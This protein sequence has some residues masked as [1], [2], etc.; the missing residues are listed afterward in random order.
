MVILC[1]VDPVFHKYELA[2]PDV[3]VILPP[4]QNVVFPF[5]VI[6]GVKGF[7]F[8]VIVVGTDEAE[9]PSEFVTVTE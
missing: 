2:E 5:G 4:W 1:I 3:N 9:H 7:E 6:V 8:T